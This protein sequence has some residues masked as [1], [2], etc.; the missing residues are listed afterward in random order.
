MSVLVESYLEQEPAPMNLGAGIG[1]AVSH[2][3]F[4]ECLPMLY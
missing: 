1:E 2:V 3:S 4:A